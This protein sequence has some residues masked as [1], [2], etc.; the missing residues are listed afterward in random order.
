MRNVTCRTRRGAVLV[1]FALVALAFYLLLAGIVTFGMIIHAAQVAQDAARVAARELA[2]VPLPADTTFDEAL[3]DPAVRAR[4]YDPDLLVID[5]DN[6]PNGLSLD[7]YVATLPAV[8]RAL[9]PAMIYDEVFVSNTTKRRLLRVPGA[10]VRSSSAPS[11][12][13]VVVPRV[14]GRDAS[15]HET[16]EWLGVVEEVRRVRSDPGSGPFSV[17]PADPLV[18][19]RGLVAIRVNIPSQSSAMG[20]F[21]PGATSGDPNVDDP[22][23]AD[24]SQVSEL[25]PGALPG[26]IPTTARTG[27]FIAFEGRYGLGRVEMLGQRVRPYRRLTTAQA[28][29]RR[30]VFTEQSQQ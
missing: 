12:L 22:N 4:V 16:I 24:D 13:T 2:L 26:A 23:L 5:L 15:G 19:D 30:E 11:G 10:I 8:N 7:A 21:A 14:A 17:A 25:N 29:F 9:R 20:S 28:F 18:V 27:A 6:I 1:E 3:A